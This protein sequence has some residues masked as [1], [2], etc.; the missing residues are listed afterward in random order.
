[1]LPNYWTD[2]RGRF[3]HC[4]QV[5]CCRILSQENSWKKVSTVTLVAFFLMHFGLWSCCTKAGKEWIQRQA[6]CQKY[7]SMLSICIA[8]KDAFQKR[9]GEYRSFCLSSHFDICWQ[10]V[11][12]ALMVGKGLKRTETGLQS[13][14]RMGSA[15]AGSCFTNHGN[16]QENNWFQLSQLTDHYLITYSALLAL[17]W[18][19]HSQLKSSFMHL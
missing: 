12:S 4:L 10:P 9:Q 16:S 18:I 7:K 11:P 6:C 13:A 5:K 3:I 8:I 17:A 2:G 15:A 19:F 1:M 14:E